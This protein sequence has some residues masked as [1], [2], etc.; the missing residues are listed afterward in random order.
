MSVAL[1]Q[2]LKTVLASVSPV[3][4]IWPR[5]PDNPTFPASL[6]Q[7]V[8]TVR[9]SSVDGQNVGPTEASFQ[10]DTISDSYL[11]AKQQA[12]A[13]REVLHTYSGSWGPLTAHWVTLE[14]ENDL[15]E[16]EGDKITHMVSQRYT[17]WTN[18]S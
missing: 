17:V 7:R 16:Q 14:T 18:M 2:G 10:I 8:S 1:E 5:L 12:D 13:I 11:E 6:Y 15:K 4:N 3:I 9:T